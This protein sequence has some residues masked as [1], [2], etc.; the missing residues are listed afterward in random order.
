MLLQGGTPCLGQL[1]IFGDHGDKPRR[2]CPQKTLVVFPSL[3]SQSSPHRASLEAPTLPDPPETLPWILGSSSSP[4]LGHLTTSPWSSLIHDSLLQGRT[5]CESQPC[6]LGQVTSL[7][8]SLILPVI[9]MGLR[10]LPSQSGYEDP[11]SQW[12]GEGLAYGWVP[13]KCLQKQNSFKASPVSC[14]QHGFPPFPCPGTRY[15]NQMC[16]WASL[17]RM[18]YLGTRINGEFSLVNYGSC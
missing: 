9:E 6:D 4:G 7:L 10:I 12:A 13:K 5:R 15:S 18:S 16:L 17:G 14:S 2:L 8:F 1:R 11:G 3:R